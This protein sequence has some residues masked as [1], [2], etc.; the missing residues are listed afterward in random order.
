MDAR[1][2]EQLYFLRQL[3]ASGRYDTE[4]LVIEN[5]EQ[6]IADV[7]TY[8]KSAGYDM[9]LACMDL[10]IEKKQ[11]KFRKDGK[12]PSIIHEVSQAIYTISLMEAGVHLEDPESVIALNFIHD[13]G[14]DF[15]FKPDELVDYLHQQKIA[16][17]DKIPQLT[18][19]FDLMSKKYKNE[20][21]KFTYEIEYYRTLQES[22]NASIAKLID[23]IH[24]VATQIGVQDDQRCSEYIRNTELIINDYV[25]YA[26][27]KFPEQEEAYE[28]SKGMLKTLCQINRYYLAREEMGKRLPSSAELK[29]EMPERGFKVPLGLNPIYLSANRVTNQPGW[30]RDEPL[31]Y[32]LDFPDFLPNW[33]EKLTFPS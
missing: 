1:A 8:L 24:N 22:Q 20:E 7:R 21:P 6:L 16:D 23:R 29:E 4:D 17:F 25:L 28:N 31:Y 27:R 15:G 14:E 19:D 32:N 10:A 11:G 30:K 2:D 9:A 33:I 12:T 5:S 18:V 3:S 26:S 13:L